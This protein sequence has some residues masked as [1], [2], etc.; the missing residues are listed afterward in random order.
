MLFSLITLSP[1]LQIERTRILG[2][3]WEGRSIVQDCGGLVLAAW[4]EVRLRPRCCTNMPQS[5][6]QIA[7]RPVTQDLA[8]LA[9]AGSCQGARCSKAAMSGQ[10]MRAVLTTCAG[11]P[12]VSRRG[13]RGPSL[14]TLTKRGCRCR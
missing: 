6:H 13:D 5:P 10:K 4:L 8:P 14:A 3:S 12:E 9:Q 11:S 1:R 7:A 2:A